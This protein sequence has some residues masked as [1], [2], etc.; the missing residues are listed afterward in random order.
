MANSGGSECQ[1]RPLDVSSAPAVL[2][3][4]FAKVSAEKEAEEWDK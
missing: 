3:D 4:I 2:K 1:I